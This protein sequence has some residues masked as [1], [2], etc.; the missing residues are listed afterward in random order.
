MGAGGKFLT[1]LDGSRILESLGKIE[2]LAFAKTSLLALAN[3][4]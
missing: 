4:L 3:D 1:S 2:T